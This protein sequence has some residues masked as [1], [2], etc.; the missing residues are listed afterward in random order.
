MS[1]YTSSD[2]LTMY[3]R[4]A[5]F[6][7]SEGSASIHTEFCQE[8]LLSVKGCG[9]RR[10]LFNCMSHFSNGLFYVDISVL[11]VFMSKHLRPPC[12]QYTTP[13]R[14][15]TFAY[16]LFFRK[17]DETTTQFWATLLSEEPLSIQGSPPGGTVRSMAGKTIVK[18]V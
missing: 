18:H 9:V 3:L 2:P 4:A 15:T 1:A 12:L 16:K 10:L 11:C 8:D 14:R 13:T 5:R 7:G 17:N 6:S